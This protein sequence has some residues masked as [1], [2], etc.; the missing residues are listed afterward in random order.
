ME[1]ITSASETCPCGRPVGTV[2]F[3]RGSDD[4][5][6]LCLTCAEPYAERWMSQSVTTAASPTG[7]AIREML[8]HN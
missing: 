8:K 6:R 2:L 3:R 4:E 1:P 5:L 7:T